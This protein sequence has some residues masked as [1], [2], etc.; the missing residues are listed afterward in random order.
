MIS[1]KYGNAAV[2]V[3]WYQLLIFVHELG[4]LIVRQAGTA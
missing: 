2:V 3:R 1:V 4:S